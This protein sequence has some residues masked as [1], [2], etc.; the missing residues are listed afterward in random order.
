M[1]VDVA[2]GNAARVEYPSRDTPQLE[3]EYSTTDNTSL[4]YTFHDNNNSTVNND[5]SRVL[6][7][8]NDNTMSEYRLDSNLHSN[9]LRANV[10]SNV[11]SH[12]NRNGNDDNDEVHCGYI[13]S[14]KNVSAKYD[15]KLSTSHTQ[16]AMLIKNELDAL[17][18]AFERSM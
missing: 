4:L 16:Y 9:S 11:V 1:H 14:K 3:A 15:T 12:A 18:I 17:R 13:A 5:E 10:K 8:I 7:N 6:T 2:A